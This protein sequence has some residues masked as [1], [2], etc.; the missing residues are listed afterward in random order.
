MKKF[1]YLNKNVLTLECKMF[2][3]MNKKCINEEITCSELL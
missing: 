2:L 3:N 1:P